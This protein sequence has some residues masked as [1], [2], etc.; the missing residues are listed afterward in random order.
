MRH[1]LPLAPQFYVTAPQVCPYLPDRIE[2]KLF[3]SIQGDDAQLLNDSLSQQGFRR[4]QNI[5]YRPSCNECSACLSA[6]IDVKKFKPSKSQKKIIRRNKFL[7]RS[8]NSPW[9]T[10]EQYDL[11][12]RYLQERH[13][14]GGM[15]DMDVFEFAAMIEESSIETRVIEYHHESSLQSVCLSDF[16]SDGLS[17]VYSFFDPDKSK[18][19]LG[20]FMILDHI[21]LALELGLPYLYLGYWV[22]GSSKMDYK[23]NF[24]GVEIFQNNIWQPLS[25][26]NKS[27]LELHPLNTAPVSE[28]VSSLSLPD[29]ILT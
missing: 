25:E 8:S 15:A 16:L 10:E 20:T 27:S 1:T 13:A 23:V 11:F 26:I 19:S 24:K 12:Q 28:Q 17:M 14:K 3:T 2:R 29:S 22:P 9:A 4:S 6:R 21:A 5:L 18:Q 7:I